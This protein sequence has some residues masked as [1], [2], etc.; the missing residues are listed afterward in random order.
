MRSSILSVAIGSS[1]EHGSS[2]RITSG[3]T[4]I[5]RAMHR[6]CCWPPERPTPGS[7]RRSLTSSHRPAPTQRALDALAHV[8]AARA[9]E[10]QPGGD[11]VEDRHRRE[12]VRLLEDHADRAAHRDDVDVR[13]VDVEVVEQDLAL[14]A[15][16]GD[17]L[18]HAVDAAHERRLAAARRADHRRH[19][20]RRVV[21][22]DALDGVAVAVVGV[23]VA[24]AM[25]GA[26][27]C[28]GGPAVGA[29]GELHRGA[30]LRRGV[31]GAVVGWDISVV[32]SVARR[33]AWRAG[34][35]GS[36]GEL[37]PSLDQAGDQREQEDHRRRASGPRPT[38]AGRGGPA[39]GPRR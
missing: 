35:R 31:G 25:P 32:V 38:P 39:P 14:G 22:V 13:R 12:R 8:D 37:A 2:M 6:R 23:D 30:A 26:S 17:L 29:G 34:R 21:E 7:P 9:G 16:A 10:P 18:V 20:V 4:A 33:A 15:R 19:L 27:T 5:V 28:G 11:V 24:Q 36:C 1:A 3:S